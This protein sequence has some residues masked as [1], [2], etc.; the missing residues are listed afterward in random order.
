M[1]HIF[2]KFE[3]YAKNVF[4]CFV[5]LEKAYGRVPED[6]L[7]RVLQEYGIDWRMLRAIKLIYCQPGFCVR[8]NNKQSKSFHFGVG[9]RE[10]Y[11]LS[12]LLF[13]IYMN[14]MDKFSPTD[15]CDTI[16]RCKIGRLLFAGDL[17]LLAS[18]ESGLQHALND[19]SAACDIAAMKICT[20]KSEVVI[21]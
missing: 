1:R 11:V 8:V 4:A 14:W 20:S 15:E 6:K 9:F 5:D 12:P 17:V 3:E 18:S 10:G 7:W 13:I 21:F 16:G 19:F 2:E